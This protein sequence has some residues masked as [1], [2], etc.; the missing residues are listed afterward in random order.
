MSDGKLFQSRGAATANVLSPMVRRWQTT[1]S[2][3]TMSCCDISRSFFVV[4]LQ[5]RQGWLYT[6]LMTQWMLP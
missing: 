3:T 2:T 4:L 5:S 6:T 1:T